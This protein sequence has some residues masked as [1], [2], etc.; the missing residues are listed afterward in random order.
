[1]YPVHFFTLSLHLS[2]H[3]LPPLL[4]YS[5]L[6]WHFFRCFSLLIIWR[7]IHPQS[8]A[9]KTADNNSTMLGKWHATD[10]CNYNMPS[11]LHLSFYLPN[12]PSPSLPHCL[13]LSAISAAVIAAKF[14]H[15]SHLNRQ[16]ISP[17]IEPQWAASLPASY[18]SIKKGRSYQ[19]ERSPTVGEDDAQRDT[20]KYLSA[21]QTRASPPQL[22]AFKKSRT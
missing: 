3:Y 12:L 1:M 19:A 8:V 21:T 6:S 14:Y 20:D 13:L 18:L 15:V 16:N 10:R 4:F 9:N 22:L 2:S 5:L 11:I 17:G 7:E